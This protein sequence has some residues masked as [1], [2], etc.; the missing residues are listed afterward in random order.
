MARKKSKK[1]F[2]N[3]SAY[4]KLRTNIEYT[5]LQEGIKSVCFTSANHG[6]G[7]TTVASNLAIVSAGNKGRVLLIDCDI[8]K[9]QVHRSFGF[10]NGEGLT[11]ILRSNDFSNTSLY[12][13]KFKDKNSEGYLYV[14]PAGSRVGNSLDILSSHAFVEFMNAMKEN[15]DFIVL[16]C[17][18]M[19]TSS[20]VIP[21]SSVVD[22]TILVISSMDTDKNIAKSALTQLKRNGANVLGTVLNK[23]KQDN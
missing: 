12:T 17:P 5:S 9:P 15:F 13:R 3:V 4:R 23:T 16:D 10:D 21:V 2:M 14:M 6:A 18:S 22:G 11:D 19:E 1:N 8:D 7:T 20:D